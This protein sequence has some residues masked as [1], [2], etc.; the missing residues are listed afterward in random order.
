MRTLVI[1]DVHEQIDRLLRILQLFGPPLVDRVVQLGDLWDSFN[2]GQTEA[3]VE[4]FRREVHNPKWGLIIGNH[5]LPYMTPYGRGFECSGYTEWKDVA[6]NHRVDVEH[7]RSVARVS[8]QVGRYLLSHAGYHPS[9]L[10]YRH[11]EGSA[12]RVAYQDNTRMIPPLFTPS[13]R[14]GG[15]PGEVGGP[16][17]LDWDDFEDIPGLPQIVGHSPN[18]VVRRKGES[19][20][21]DTMLHHVGIIEDDNPIQIL[22]VD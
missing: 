4:W 10:K 7:W 17:W 16:T 19:Y 22:E 14:R 1:P 15:M 13:A 18:R 5:D 2:K 12:L 11:T 21:L 6:I 3:M 20:C 8:I 9:M